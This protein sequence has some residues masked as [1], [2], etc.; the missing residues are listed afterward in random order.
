MS[1]Q[2]TNGDDVNETPDDTRVFRW[3]TSTRGPPEA[4]ATTAD[5]SHDTVPLRGRPGAPATTGSSHRP[6]HRDAAL[7]HRLR[8]VGHRGAGAARRPGRPQAGAPAHRLCDVRRRLPARPRLQ[9]V[10]PCRRRR[11]GSVPP[12]RRHGDLRRAGPPGADWSLRYPLVD[13][14]GNF[15]SR[16]NDGAAACAVHRVPDGPLAM[17]MVRD[18]EQDTV[19]FARTTTARRRSPPSCRRGSRTCWSTAPPVSPS[20]W[21]RRSR[22]TTCARWRRGQ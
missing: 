14:Q 1:D 18:I 12:A 17:E 8:H 21:P 6:Q 5:T 20:A 4:G 15:G 16:G 19:D 13:G 9:Q 2:L 3:M 22:R 7:V 11:H 10:R